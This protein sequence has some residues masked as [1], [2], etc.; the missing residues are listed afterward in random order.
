LHDAG[1]GGPDRPQRLTATMELFRRKGILEKVKM[2]EPEPCTEEDILRVHTKEHLEYIKSVSSSGGGYI[3]ED[4]YCSPGTYEAARLAAGCCIRAAKAIM[5][6]E[7]DNAFALTRPPGHHASRNKAAGFCFFNNAAIAARYLQ[8]VLGVGRIFIYDWDAHAGN[9]TMD[10]F[11]G[12]PSV[13]N[14]SIHQDPRCF[15]PG[16]G[17]ID[18]MGTSSGEGYTVNIPVPSGSGDADYLHILEEFVIPAMHAYEPE[19]MII[20]AGQDSHTE[21]DIS[22]ISLSSDCFGEMTRRIVEEAGGIC[23]G[24]VLVELEGGYEIKSFADSN[25]AIIR[26]LL[27]EENGYEVKGEVR[28]STDLILADLRESVLPGSFAHKAP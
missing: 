19:F 7:A 28:E 2:L 5:E 1:E 13:M 25:Y 20:A 9:G 16:T 27:G 3:D 4:T 24:R 8:E 14:V 18:Q 12:D 6:K 21:D 22:G 10:I 11:Y 17:H 15:Y 26:A 23:S